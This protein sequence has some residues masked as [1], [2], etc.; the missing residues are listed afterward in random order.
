MSVDDGQVGDEAAFHDIALAVELADILAFGDLGADAGFGEERRDPGAAGADT[1]GKRTLRVE[2]DLELAG[3]VLLHEGFVLPDIGGDHFLDL[4]GI[5]Q[6][7]E[8]LP[9]GP[10][11]VGHDGQVFDPRIADRKNQGFG[12]AAQAKSA[13]H[14]GHAILKQPGQRGLPVRIDLVHERS[15][16]PGWLELRITGPAERSTRYETASSHSILGWSATN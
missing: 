3:E 2:L 14:D 1:L 15:I 16:S 5:E 4:A 11:I 7:A 8:S 12:N 9:V 10:A 13:C 6:Q